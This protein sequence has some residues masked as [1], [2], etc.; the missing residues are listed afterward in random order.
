M[1][2]G[3][4][5]WSCFITLTKWLCTWTIFAQLLYYWHCYAQFFPPEGGKGFDK[6]TQAELSSHPPLWCLEAYS[7]LY[8]LNISVRQTRHFHSQ[9]LITR[10]LDNFWSQISTGLIGKPLK[11]GNA[12]YVLL[13]YEFTLVRHWNR[14][15]ISFHRKIVCKNVEPY[16][17]KLSKINKN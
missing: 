7:L 13:Y 4:I 12:R 15:I 9:Y 3:G 16:Q 5:L 8:L 14:R 11:K 2:S 17:T 10:Y 6:K 1:T